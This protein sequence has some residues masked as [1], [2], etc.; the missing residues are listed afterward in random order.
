M[1]Q[2][3]ENKATVKAARLL[4][5]VHVKTEQRLERKLSVL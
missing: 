3:A 5:V 4:D 1:W 2:T